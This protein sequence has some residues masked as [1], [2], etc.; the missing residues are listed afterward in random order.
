MTHLHNIV[1]KNEESIE[2]HAKQLNLDG[3]ETGVMCVA[4]RQATIALLEGVVEMVEGMK[5]ELDES[6]YAQVE[7]RIKCGLL[8]FEKET[9]N[10]ALQDILTPLHEE[11]KR[12]KEDI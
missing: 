12:L 9:Y 4:N 1:K 11:I 7:D 2:R 8:N 10:Q 5:K 6:L 3:V